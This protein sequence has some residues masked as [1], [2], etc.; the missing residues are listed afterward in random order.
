VRKDASAISV[1]DDLAKEFGQ[2]RTSMVM[3]K[4]TLDELLGSSPAHVSRGRL[5]CQ[6]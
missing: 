1:A 4:W 3:L 6:D 2:V 5:L